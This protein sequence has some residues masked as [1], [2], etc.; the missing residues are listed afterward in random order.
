MMLFSVPHAC[1]K[2]CKLSGYEIPKGTLVFC[3]LGAVMA[4][5]DTF[6]NPK[7]VDPG[8]DLIKNEDG[9]LKFKPHPK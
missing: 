5:P 1:L 7:K 8:R 9:K 2:D 3:N 6:S 4:D